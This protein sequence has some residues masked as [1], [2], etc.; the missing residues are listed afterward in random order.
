M[1]EKLVLI[2]SSE[3]EEIVSRSVRVALADAQAATPQAVPEEILTRKQISEMFGRSLVTINDWMQKGLLP[4]YRISRKVY[5]KKS[6]VL[7]AMQKSGKR[8]GG[9]K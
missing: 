1:T 4:Y 2:A 3:L 6:E 9:V 7:N 5:F 8:K